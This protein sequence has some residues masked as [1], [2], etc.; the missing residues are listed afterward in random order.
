VIKLKLKI[1]EIDAILTALGDQPYVKVAELVV[2]IRQQ[3]L[4]QYESLKEQ[5]NILDDETEKVS[6]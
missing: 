1:E 2:K 4:P 5:E 6:E 3:A